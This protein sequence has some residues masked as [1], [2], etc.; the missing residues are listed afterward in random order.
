MQLGRAE[1]E[2]IEGALKGLQN[3]DD[4][5]EVLRQMKEADVYALDTETVPWKSRNDYFKVP[6][7]GISVSVNGRQATYCT[8]PEKWHQFLPREGQKVVMHNSKFDLLTLERHGLHI[9]SSQIEDTKIAAYLIN[10][11]LF[12]YN[13]KSLAQRYLGVQNPMLWEEAENKGKTVDPEV[14][15][16][17]ARNDA[18]Y[19]IQLWNSFSPVLTR[20][21]LQKVYRIEKNLV[22]VLIEVESTGMKIDASKID[23]LRALVNRDM[24]NLEQSIWDCAGREFNINSTD[25]LGEFLFDDLG[26]SPQKWTKGGKKGIQKRSTDRESLQFLSDDHKIIESILEY[27]GYQKLDSAFLKSLPRFLDENNRI[28]PSFNAQGA[29]TG[30]MSCSNPNVQQIPSRT[31]LGKEI[32]KAFIPEEGF[33]LIVAD[34]GAQEMRV[35]ASYLITLAKDYSLAKAIEAGDPHDYTAKAMGQKAGK[36]IARVVAKMINFGIAYGITNIG[37]SRRLTAQRYPINEYEAQDFIDLY[38]QSYPGMDKFFR[39]VWDQVLTY[40]Y[41][42]NAYGRRRRLGG[43]SP[44]ELRQAGNYVIQGTSA[45]I[46]KDSMVSVYRELKTHIPDARIIA[47][48]H[49]ELLIECPDEEAERGKKIVEEMMMQCS[50][51]MPVGMTVDT[52]IGKS[53]AEAKG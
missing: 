4:E 6:L 1:V 44:R 20:E 11:N 19:T 35:L 17:Y 29:K 16:E 2:Q 8:N 5:R 40:G 18:R 48:I 45:D 32:R 25:Q 52:H 31:D 43:G 49:D 28:H 21:G 14:F 10:E 47:Q 42:K 51:K 39:A 26:L 13:L 9:D 24:R 50:V 30:R 27:K 36:E 37:L 7:L 3:Q 46:V 34:Y 41:V 15:N 33:S 12:Q 38:F 22:P 23:Y 53:W